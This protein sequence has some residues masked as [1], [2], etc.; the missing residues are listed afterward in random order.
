MK[1]YEYSQGLQSHGLYVKH[2]VKY[3][4]DPCRSLHEVLQL[5]RESF[6]KTEEPSVTRRMNPDFE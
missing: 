1:S 4:D 3:I 2:L 5:V 6:N